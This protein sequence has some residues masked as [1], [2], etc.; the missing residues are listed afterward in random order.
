MMWCSTMSWISS[1]VGARFIFWHCSS[2]DSAMRW[3][4]MGVI[5]S[6]SATDSLAL[7]MAMMILVMSKPTSAP[8]LLMIFMENSS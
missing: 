3:I 1:T 8:F 4:C 6:A 5:R 2:T 7:V